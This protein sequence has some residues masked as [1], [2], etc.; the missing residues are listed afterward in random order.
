MP[1]AEGV[2]SHENTGFSEVRQIPVWPGFGFRDMPL[3]ESVCYRK[4]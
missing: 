2:L 1:P 3:P 4:T